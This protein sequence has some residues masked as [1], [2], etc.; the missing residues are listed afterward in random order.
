MTRVA[1]LDGYRTPHGV[2]GGAL[3][4][5]TA[6]KLGETAAREVIK[7]TGVNVDDIDEVVF[8]CVGQFSDAPNLARVISLNSGVPF[9]KIAHT[10]QRNCASAM[11]AVVDATRILKLGEA[12]MILAGGAESMSSAPYVSRDMRFGKR[13]RNSEFIDTLWEGL[14]DPVCNMIMGRT[15]ENLAEEFKITREQ[16]D[17]FAVQS[18]Q[19][20]FRA[21]REGRFKEEIVPVTVPKKAAGREVEPDIFSE[22]EGIN[23]ALNE[24]TLALYP[25]IFKEGGTVTPGNACG[26]N[27]GGAAVLMTTEEN[28]QKLGIEPLGYVVSYAFAGVEPERMGIGPAFA[29]PLAL[30]KAGWKLEDVDLI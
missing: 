23:V 10:V 27:D 5:I 1:I 6:Q 4:T 25:T 18:H 30:E 15:A 22:D 26:I 14:T 28:A 19:K 11:Q 21:T 24:K 17:K 12:G 13:M 3:R 7:K 9:K 16:Q 29:A 2:L 8:G 20:A